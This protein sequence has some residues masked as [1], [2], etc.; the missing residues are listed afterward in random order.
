M[1]IQVAL[2][3]NSNNGAIWSQKVMEAVKY[4][5]TATRRPL[6]TFCLLTEAA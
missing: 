2:A 4:L 3:S 5:Q 6:G 1:I